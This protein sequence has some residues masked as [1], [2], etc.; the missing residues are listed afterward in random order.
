VKESKV[1]I[2]WNRLAQLSVAAL[3]IGVLLVGA[4]ASTAAA[5][6]GGN[7][8][9]GSRLNPLSA[10]EIQAL[11]DAIN[12]EYLALNTYNAVIAQFGRTIPFSNI[13]RAEQQHVDTLAQ[14]FTKY[15]QTVPANPGLSPV[16]TWADKTAACQTGVETETVDAVLYDQLIPLVN[17]RDI[18][19]VF[20]NLQAASLT[21]HLPA[22]D[23]CN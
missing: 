5:A 10:D 6:R 21:K 7:G 20:G 18:L 22:F 17:H 19:N 9:R 11:T 14:L 13:A 3:V 23:R 2:R 16:P 8:D 15:G 1:N 4:G 12:E